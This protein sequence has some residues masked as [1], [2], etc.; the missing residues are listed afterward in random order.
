MDAEVQVALTV[1]ESK[2]SAVQ[3][4]LGEANA[5]LLWTGAASSA[6]IVAVPDGSMARTAP[7]RSR[8]EM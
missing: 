3:V 1:E 8:A 7:R 2:S 5:L 6:G 4:L